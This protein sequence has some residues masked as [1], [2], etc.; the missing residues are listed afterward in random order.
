MTAFNII[1]N[2]KLF[3]GRENSYLLGET[4][5]HRLSTIGPYLSCVQL[6]VTLPIQGLI[7]NN[8]TVVHVCVGRPQKLHPTRHHNLHTREA[9]VTW[10]SPVFT[11]TIPYLQVMIR[12]PVLTR[13]ENTDLSVRMFFSIVKDSK[14]ELV[15]IH[16][17][18]HLV[19]NMLS[20]FGSSFAL[21]G[22]T[23]P[24]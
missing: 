7:S 19:D 10:V 21:R 9:G 20:D 14:L 1:S 5:R 11:W 18:F 13:C 6:S 3:V 2:K 22:Q 24:N 12:F 8:Q 4:T 23:E 16:L 17:L 15:E